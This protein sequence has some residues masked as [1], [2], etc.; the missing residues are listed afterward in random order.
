MMPGKV[1]PV[2]LEM[3]LGVA[4][5]VH[6]NDGLITGL[7]AGGELEL[8]AFLPLAAHT[9]LQ[10]VDFLSQA[11]GKFRS[12][13]VEGLGADAAVCRRRLLEAPSSATVLVPGYGYHV[14]SQIA[15]IMQ[16]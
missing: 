13:C 16:R 12:R 11:A 15:G 9:F 4:R 5:L 3:V 1:N 2:I 7:L 8:N 6:H 14:A 10:S